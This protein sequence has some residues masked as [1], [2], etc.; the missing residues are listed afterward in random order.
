MNTKIQSSIRTGIG[1]LVLHLISGCGGVYV[2]D[3][4]YKT[5]QL[6]EAC[7]QTDKTQCTTMYV[8]GKQMIDNESAAFRAAF[9]EAQK[10]ETDRNRLLIR[11][12]LLSDEICKNHQ[13]DIRGTA[14]ALNLTFGTLTTLFSGAA[15]LS[16]GT[17]AR[18]LADLAP[19]FRSS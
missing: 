9:T 8:S 10:L 6:P 5:Q 17:A 1:L 7:L 18:T 4:I 12:R 14:T 3:S 19:V 13:G 2:V 15:A 16:A 11:I